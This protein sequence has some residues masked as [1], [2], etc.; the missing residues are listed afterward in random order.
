M[1]ILILGA[2]GD[3][4]RLTTEKALAAGHDVTA[5][6]RN[7]GKVTANNPRLSVIKG[8]LG[9]VAAIRAAME[10]QDAVISLLGP[11]GKAA[12]MVYSAAMQTI[13]EAMRSAGVRR[14]IAT[15]TPSAADPKDRFSLPFWLAVKMIRLMAGDACADLSALGKVVSDS[16]LD[17]TLVR[18]PWLTSKP[19][20]RPAVAGYV[21]DKSIKLFFLSRQRLADFLI[22]QL[23][24]TTWVNKAPAISNG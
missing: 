1:N 10:G 13:V 6:V 20:A 21:G 9:D 8:E 17:W 18:L 12:G 16:G 24:D 5:Y 15:A 11:A 23:T 19:H 2:T 3:S 7:P 4:G 14:L 22:D